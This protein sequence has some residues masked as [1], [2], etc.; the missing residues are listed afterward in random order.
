MENTVQM[1]LC[2]SHNLTLAS[3][4]PLPLLTI[5]MHTGTSRTTNGD[6]TKDEKAQ[7]PGNSTRDKPT[8][9]ISKEKLTYMI[10]E[11]IEHYRVKYKYERS[12]VEWLYKIFDEEID[13]ISLCARGL[14]EIKDRQ[15]IGESVVPVFT[16]LIPAG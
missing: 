8:I 16:E 15:S 10:R 5:T 9:F 14:A 12:D 6:T 3:T 13:T 4:S 2:L 7:E 1:S 11:V